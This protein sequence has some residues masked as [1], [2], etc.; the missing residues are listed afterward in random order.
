MAE[1]D[2]NWQKLAGMT[3]NSWNVWKWINMAGMAA[4]SFRPASCA[5]LCRAGPYKCKDD[6]RLRFPDLLL[7]FATIFNTLLTRAHPWNFGYRR[8]L[9]QMNL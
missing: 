6:N 9:G 3:G 1:T 8:D 7:N 4:A 5:R 2:W